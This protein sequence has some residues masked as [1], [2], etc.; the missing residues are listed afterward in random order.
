M[1]CSETVW[2]KGWTDIVAETGRVGK[3]GF[4][5]A[6]TPI[7]YRNQVVCKNKKTAGNQPFSRKGLAQVAFYINQRAAGQSQ[8]GFGFVQYG[9]QEQA[10]VFLQRA[11]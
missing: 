11:D 1:G 8:V 2:E 3:Q 9:V 6:K 10:F 7:I 4:C 5:E